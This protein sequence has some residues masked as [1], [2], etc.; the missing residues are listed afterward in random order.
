MQMFKLLCTETVNQIGGNFGRSFWSIDVLRATQAYPAIWHACLAVAS[1]HE[2]MKTPSEMTPIG[3][4]SRHYD[5]SIQQYNASIKHLI[6][7]GRRSTPT[8]A[9]QE[10]VLMGSILLHMLCCLQGDMH[11]GTVHARNGLQLFYQWRFW[12]RLY[13]SKRLKKHDG[14]F[15]PSSLAVLM[16][17]IESQMAN[18]VS[19]VPRPLWHRLCIPYK[20]SATPFAS[21]TDAYVEFQRLFTGFLTATQF[22]ESPPSLIPEPKPDSRANYRREFEVWKRKFEKLKA[23]SET[24][25]EDLEGILL[26]NILFIGVVVCLYVNL[27][28]GEL[29][30][31]RYRSSFEQITD[32]T[33]DLLSKQAKSGKAGNK[34]TPTFSFSSSLCELLS[35]AGM[36]CRDR[37]IRRKAIVIMKTWPRRDGIW[38]S[39]LAASACGAVMNLEEEAIMRDNWGCECRPDGY[40]C[41]YHRVTS[42]ETEFL[43]N[44]MAKLTMNTVGG[45]RMGHPPHV[46][47]LTL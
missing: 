37:I 46:V 45:V 35:W 14:L 2:S 6:D 41:S 18:R 3:S 29:D 17:F 43:P 27:G 38:D 1:M 13:K 39:R 20:C 28:D 25:G 36:H 11:Q 19:N 33:E 21:V 5:F 8:L 30:Y 12:E 40:I 31:D 23:S 47:I 16:S 24:Q 10:T 26:L 4:K 32:L 9:D 7:I 15:E 42:T 22:G 34:S 44:S